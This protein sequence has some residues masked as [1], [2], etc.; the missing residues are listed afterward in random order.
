MLPQAEREEIEQNAL[1]TK[2]DLLKGKNNEWK[3]TTLDW[4]GVLLGGE[5]HENTIV[6][7]HDLRVSTLYHPDRKT[8]YDGVD[9]PDFKMDD[10]V[11]PRYNIADVLGRV[12]F[13]LCM[14]VGYMFLF[15]F[16]WALLH[17]HTDYILQLRARMNN[18]R[19]GRKTGKGSFALG[20][21]YYNRRVVYAKYV[22]FLYFF[23]HYVAFTR[24]MDDDEW[25]FFTIFRM[26]YYQTSLFPFVH[27]RDICVSLFYA[28]N[29][30]FVAFCGI[31]LF[32]FPTRIA[33]RGDRRD[34]GLNVAKHVKSK[35]LYTNQANIFASNRK[36]T[37]AIFFMLAFFAIAM[38]VSAILALWTAGDGKALQNYRLYEVAN[39]REAKKAAL[40]YKIFLNF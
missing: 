31:L 30:A 17:L 37:V 10:K 18:A 22:L 27:W 32:M 35:V 33:L 29:V 12:M 28:G 11:N 13:S 1:E 38:P 40:P 2:L 24:R 3:D 25:E 16:L 4:A 8:L 14:H 21:D 36:M 15:I 23:L 20:P 34:E 9:Y 26:G 19:Q 5:K 7:W 6:G 39:L